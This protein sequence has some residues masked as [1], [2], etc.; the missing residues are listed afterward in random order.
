MRY[1]QKYINGFNNK[2]NKKN[3]QENMANHSSYP[4][5]FFLKVGIFFYDHW[6]L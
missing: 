4:L 3:M 5:H 6:T 2:K 1:A